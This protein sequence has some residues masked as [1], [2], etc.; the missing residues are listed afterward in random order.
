MWIPFNFMI[1]FIWFERYC[2]V[3]STIPCENIYPVCMCYWNSMIQILLPI[4]R[5]TSHNIQF[6]S[7]IEGSLSKCPFET[8]HSASNS[9]DVHA[10]KF[11]LVQYDSFYNGQIQQDGS[12]CF[13]MLIE[14]INVP[15]CGS[16]DNDSKGVSLSEI[17][18]SYMSKKIYRLQCMWAECLL[19]KRTG[20]WV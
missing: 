9:A 4:L 17:L 7:R 16:N 14:V 5:T 2:Q 3:F 1:S 6:N 10:L 8:A 11:R 15:Y 12:D 20:C 18:F 19:I 13:M